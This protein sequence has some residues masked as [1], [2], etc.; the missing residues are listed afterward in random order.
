MCVKEREQ[1]VIVGGRSWRTTP[2]FLIGDTE[3]LLMPFIQFFTRE[4]RDLEQI[5]RA[6]VGFMFNSGQVNLR[7]L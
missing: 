7:Y 5:I 6:G 4:L 2:G 3:G 1:K